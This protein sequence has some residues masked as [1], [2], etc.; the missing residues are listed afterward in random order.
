MACSAS[1]VIRTRITWDHTRG[2]CDEIAGVG[3]YGVI[4]EE[5]QGDDIIMKLS[6]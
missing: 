1:S 4:I 6:N 5:V 3:P 2:K